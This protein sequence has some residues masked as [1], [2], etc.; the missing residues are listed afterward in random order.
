[1]YL[2]M[3]RFT[4]DDV[5]V[6]LFATWQEAVDRC[7]Q[8]DNDAND[9]AND[10]QEVRRLAERLL[11]VTPSDYLGSAIIEFEGTKPKRA[12]HYSSFEHGY[13]KSSAEAYRAFEVFASEQS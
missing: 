12:A 7:I 5:P 6:G 13:F 1:M 2:V 4:L 9:E 10:A 8:L 3:A 11:N